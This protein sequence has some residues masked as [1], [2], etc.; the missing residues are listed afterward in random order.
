[1]PK[2]N[3]RL[4]TYIHTSISTLISIISATCAIVTMRALP[5]VV[6]LARRIQNTSYVRRIGRRISDQRRIGQNMKKKTKLTN[7]QNATAGFWV[8]YLASDHRSVRR[9]GRRIQK[10]ASD[11]TSD[12]ETCVG[13][14]V[15]SG[16]GSK[17]SRSAKPPLTTANGPAVCSS[18]NRAHYDTCGR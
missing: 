8:I 3:M 16:V 12:P 6:F 17:K 14:G 18:P 13:S 4:C 11:R 7:A 15:G 5:G 1:M 10:R 9:I 2:S